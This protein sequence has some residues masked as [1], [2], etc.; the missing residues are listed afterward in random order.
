MKGLF[1][2]G[3]GTNVGK[4]FFA[5]ALVRYLSKTQLISVRKPLESD[6]QLKNGT[7]HP[8]D[9]QQLFKANNELE[10]LEA[11][12]KFRFSAC[13]D[14]ESASKEASNPPDLPALLEA[15]Q[16]ENFVVVE[17]AGGLFSPICQNTL[18]SDLAKNLDLGLVLVIKDE[19]GAI[20]QALLALVGAKAK[21]LEVACVVLNRFSVNNLDNLQAIKRYSSVPVVLFSGVIEADFLALIQ[22][23]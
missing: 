19:L 4:T 6:C 23:S 1:I 14:G 15:C 18:N 13:A 17:G 11:V 20:N 12:C 9:A 22:Q 21:G 7:L 16:S 2:S 3:S 10:S 5:S 8:K